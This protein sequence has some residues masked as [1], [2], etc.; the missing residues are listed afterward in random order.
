MHVNMKTRNL[1]ITICLSLSALSL[2]AQSIYS[3]TPLNGFGTTGNGEILADGS[4]PFLTSSAAIQR[5][6]AYNP[7]TG[8]LIFVDRGVAGQ[9]ADV[10]GGIYVLNGTTGAVISTL[11][12]NGIQGGSFAHY[13]TGVGDDGAVY[14]A[15]VVANTNAGAF[16]VYRWASETSTDAPT[17]AFSGIL[18]TNNF[19]WGNTIDVRGSGPDTQILVSA[20]G[21]EA[22]VLTTTDGVNFTATVLTTD[23]SASLQGNLMFGNGNTYWAKFSSQPLRLLSFD[24]ALGT[25]TTIRSYGTAEMPEIVPCETM[26][27]DNVNHLLVTVRYRNDVAD[28]V[29]LYSISNTNDVPQLLETLSPSN[30]SNAQSG[31]PKGYLMF[32]GGN[33]YFHNINNGIFAFNLVSGAPP[34]PVIVTQPSPVKL[35]IG[36]TAKMRVIAQYGTS[37]QWRKGATDIPGATNSVLVL[38]NIQLADTGNYSVVVSNSTDSVTSSPATLTV[39]S[40]EDF[41]HLVPLWS[42]A[43]DSQPYLLLAGST[44]GGPNQRDIAYNEEKDHLYVVARTG[45]TT[46]FNVWVVDGE[47]GAALY[48]LNTNGSNFSGWEGGIGLD[49]IDVADD[50]SIYAANLD[51][52]SAGSTPAVWRVYRWADDSSNTVPTMVFA[53]DPLNSGASF[54]WGDAMDVRGAG[55]NTQI[56]VDNREANDPSSSFVAILKPTDDTL[57]SFTSQFFFMENTN[58]GNGFAKTLQ[59]GTDDSFWQQRRGRPLVHSSFDLMDGSFLAPVIEVFDSFPDTLAP[60]TFDFSRNLAGAVDIVGNTGAPDQINLYDITDLSLPV[61]LSHFPFPENRRSNSGNFAQVVFGAD[62]MFALEA[63]NG[64]VAF[65]LEMG[66]PAPTLNF[67]RSGNDII[68]SWDGADFLLEGAT[69][70]TSP[71]WENIPYTAGSPNVVTNAASENA[72]FYRLRKQ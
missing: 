25:A 70:L 34:A 22:A 67:A 45:G 36:S 21:S 47:T 71:V 46:E 52:S 69:N 15:N 51:V 23:F 6:M 65:R 24:L 56:L 8:N 66:A 72:K 64:V 49:C 9:S 29:T 48:T 38:T 16:K 61:L 41:Y 39:L 19:R 53:G 50:G 62:K 40:L 5:G 26:A 57:S 31:S 28:E 54:R 14:V 30:I 33:V 55:I 1:L 12:T 63:R 60:I 3:F 11:N 17:V 59:F 7:A 37:F 32:G 58:A 10:S 18:G 43:M 27:V 35:L 2:R 44:A 20:G 68:L 13:A 42:A 4:V